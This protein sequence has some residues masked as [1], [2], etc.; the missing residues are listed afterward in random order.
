METEKIKIELNGRSVVFYFTP[1]ET[2]NKP[3]IFIFHGHGYNKSHSAFK[4]PNFNVVCP[5]DDFGYE[6]LGSWYL[7]E[8]GDFFWLD[9]MREIMRLVKERAGRSHL[10][11]WGSSMGGYASILYGHLLGATAI[12]ANVPQTFLLGSRYSE[13]GMKKYFQKIFSN[14][15]SD[16]NDLKK[17]IKKRTRC[18]Y[19]LCFNQLEGSNY[20][21]EQ[22]LNFISCLHGLRQPMYVEVRPQS[23]HGKNHSVSE[24]INLFKRYSNSD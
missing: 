20:F 17:V 5:I 10:F 2:N 12:Y 16:F 11:M 7:G 19:F 8:Q 13:N 23:A 9:A 15:D 3:I 1:A 24:S 14:E 18:T 21:E 22:G 4:S 6:G